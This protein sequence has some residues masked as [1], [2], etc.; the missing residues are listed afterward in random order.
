MTRACVGKSR[1]VSHEKNLL[2]VEVF[3]DSLWSLSPHLFLAPVQ[4]TP[5]LFI[6]EEFKFAYILIPIHAIK[7]AIGMSSFSAR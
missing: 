2:S 7:D 1:F 4:L 3:D 6:F 5:I